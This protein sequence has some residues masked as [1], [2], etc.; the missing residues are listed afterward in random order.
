[1]RRTRPPENLAIVALLS[2]LTFAGDT[3]LGG[4]FRAQNALSKDAAW[5]S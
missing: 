3:T 4:G 1:M 5:V 2:Q